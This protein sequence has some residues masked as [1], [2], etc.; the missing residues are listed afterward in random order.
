MIKDEIKKII[1]KA[2]KDFTGSPALRESALREFSVE[3]PGDKSHGDYSTNIALILSKK[4]GKNPRE[5]A[6]EIKNKI[7]K[8]NL[9]YKIEVAGP[10]FINFFISDK[11]FIDTLKNIDKN[12]GKAEGSERGRKIIIDYTDPNILKEFHIGHLMSNSVGESLSR[13]FEFEGA[14]V[15]RVCYQSD[16]GMGVAKAIW[17][18]IKKENESWGEVYAFGAKAFEESEESKKEIIELNKKIFEKGDTKINKLY[19]EGKKESLKHFDDIY[20]KLGTKFDELIFESQVADLGKKIVE[21]GLKDRIFEKGDNGAV[22]FKGEKYGLHTRVFINSEGLP[23]YEAKD[24]GLAKFKYGGYKYDE[25]VVITANEQNDY[26]K[27]MLRAMGEVLPELAKKTKHISHGMLRLPEGKMSSRTGKV[28]TGESLIEKVEELVKEKI[29]D[30]ELSEKEKNEIVEAVAIGAIKYSVL[31][32]SIGNDIIYD[33]D[34]SIS[35]EG[36]SGPYLQYA[37]TRANSVL[38]KAKREGVKASFRK[39]PK[40][41]TRLEKTLSYF[42]EVIEKSGKEYEPHFLVLY[43]TE[44]AGIFNNYYAK[45]KIVDKKDEYSPYRVAL[46]AAFLK[47]MKNGL[48]LLGINTLEKM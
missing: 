24:L 10:G 20:K 42:P 39:T 2:I 8:N 37:Y 26:F 19:D 14:T 7:G 15:K 16:V 45:H 46:T 44:L 29:K 4:L 6:E 17:G 34:K 31:K 47:T 11:Y 23:T 3:I 32:Q 28:I 12:Y 1:E 25:S 21:K 43:L 35:F 5:V 9:F 18:K 30:R 27:V 40:E 48:W 36:D 41:I 38:E 33:F 22:I 13:I